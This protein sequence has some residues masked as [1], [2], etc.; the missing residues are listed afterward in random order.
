MVMVNFIPMYKCPC[1]KLLICLTKLH[2]F[3]TEFVCLS[4]EMENDSKFLICHTMRLV[5]VDIGCRSCAFDAEKAGYFSC[6]V[7]L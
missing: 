2:M 5:K 6:R 7:L 3:D 1:L 4:V